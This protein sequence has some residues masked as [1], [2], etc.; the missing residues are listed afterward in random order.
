MRTALEIKKKWMTV[1]LPEDLLK[2]VDEIAATPGYGYTSRSEFI[3][4]CV[5]L[6]LQEIE[7]QKSAST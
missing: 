6:R 2:Q 7:R 3:K 1:Q 4:E 5:R